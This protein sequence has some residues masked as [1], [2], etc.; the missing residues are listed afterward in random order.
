MAT[1][2]SGCF[3]PMTFN[4][5]LFVLCGHVKDTVDDD[6]LPATSLELV[7]RVWSA[8]IGT[9]ATLTEHE[10]CY[11]CWCTYDELT[12]YGMRRS[13]NVEHKMCCFFVPHTS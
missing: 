13:Q 7:E 8:A 6:T 1:L 4:T 2:L 9:P 12:E 11:V 10:Y 3:I 5:S